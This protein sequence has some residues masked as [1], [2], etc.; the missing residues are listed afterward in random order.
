MARLDVEVAGLGPAPEQTSDHSDQHDIGRDEDRRLQAESV[1]SEA[2][3]SASSAVRADEL[4]RVD[5][6]AVGASTS[7]QCAPTVCMTLPTSIGMN[8]TLTK[9]AQELK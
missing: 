1:C 6:Q 2:Q 3:S 7:S 5:G 4:D 8:Q 9:S